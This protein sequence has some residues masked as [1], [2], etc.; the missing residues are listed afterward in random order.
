MHGVSSCSFRGHFWWTSKPCLNLT[1]TW[2][3]FISLP[4][5][6][7]SLVCFIWSRNH[8][9]MMVWT[10][11][12]PNSQYHE[13]HWFCALCCHLLTAWPF[14][15]HATPPFMRFMTKQHTFFMHAHD[16]PNWPN[17]EMFHLPF[18]L[19]PLSPKPHEF[20]PSSTPFQL[21]KT[22]CNSP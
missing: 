4:S 15:M 17:M 7:K 19:F 5:I 8:E 21:P 12:I 10:L 3:L 22:T 14:H 1:S 16:A 20:W 9:V 6:Q 13:Y 18:L 2:N 11:L